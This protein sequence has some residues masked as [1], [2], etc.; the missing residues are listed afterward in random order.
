MLGFMDH[1]FSQYFNEGL[2]LEK[3]DD[4]KVFNTF[5]SG[6]FNGEAIK[7]FKNIR[8]IHRLRIGIVNTLNFS[9]MTR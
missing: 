5:M 7:T 6:Y 9:L 4:W 2:N 1:I 3:F 8:E